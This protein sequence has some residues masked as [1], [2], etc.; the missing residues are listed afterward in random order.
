LIGSL[1]PVFAAPPKD[2]RRV[3]EHLEFLGFT[4]KI[5]SDVLQAT[6][7]NHFSIYA[8]DSDLGI[9]FTLFFPINANAVQNKARLM[10]L[11]NK[12]NAEALVIKFYLDDEDDIAFE[13][14]YA[15]DYDRQEFGVFMQAYLSD[16]RLV[17]QNYE[18]ADYID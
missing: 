6:H 1:N 18:L 2:A 14:I 5:D 8:S 17:Y 15:G 3:A 9:R 16:Y 4:S 7:P 10:E 12:L 13:A 11:L